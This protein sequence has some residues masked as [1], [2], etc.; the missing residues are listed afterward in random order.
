MENLDKSPFIVYKGKKGYLTGDLGYV[1]DGMIYYKSRKDK[2]IKYKGYRIELSDI[3]KNIYSLGYVENAIVTTKKSK[4]D[5]IVKL[6]AFVKLKSNTYKEEMEIKKD[7]K[8]MIPDYMCP[9]I[10]IISEIPLTRNGKCDERKLL[11]EC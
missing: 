8:K 4:E 2:Q 3:E 9:S 1:Q 7:L 10:K 11:E 5:K 6:I